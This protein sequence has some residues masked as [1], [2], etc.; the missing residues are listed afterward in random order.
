MELILGVIMDQVIE[1]KNMENTIFTQD[2]IQEL[3]YD[4]QQLVTDLGWDY[5][6]L[7]RGGK[8]TY[9]ELCKKLNID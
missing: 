4:V 2:Q 1:N 8:D 9:D 6:R 7:T 3:L 5:E